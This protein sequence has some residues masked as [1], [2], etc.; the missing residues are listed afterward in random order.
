M[1][2]LYLVSQ[3]GMAKCASTNCTEYQVENDGILILASHW[4][5]QMRLVVC[6]KGI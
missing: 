2:H 4:Q 6:C 3:S 1:V 5:D